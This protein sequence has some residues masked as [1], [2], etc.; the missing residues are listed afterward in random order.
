MTK[1]EMV[2]R[3]FSLI[4]QFSSNE[5]EFTSILHPEFRQREFPNQLNKT[6]QESDLAD[7][8]KRAAM[9]RKMLSNQKFEITNSVEMGDQV[10]V[11]SLW[12]GSM[13][14]DAGPLKAGQELKA[15]FCIVL[16]FKEGLLF[17]QRNYDCFEPF[18]A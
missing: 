7:L 16:E 17:R 15:Q 18:S 11:E 12:S 8:L 4:E 1:I 3:Y 9:G 6:G 5:S 2:K 14:M 13:A 10:V